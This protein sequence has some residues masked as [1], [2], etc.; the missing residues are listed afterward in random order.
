MLLT[1][2]AR[3][4]RNA[5][6]RFGP[7]VPVVLAWASV[8]QAPQFCDEQLLA[9]DEI[10]GR[11]LDA[12]PPEQRPAASAAERQRRQAPAGTCERSAPCCSGG[13][14][15]K[16]RGTPRAVAAAPARSAAADPLV[17]WPAM[18]MRQKYRMRTPSTGREVI[19]EAEPDQIYLDRET[20]EQLEVVGELLPLAP[21][22]RSCPGRWTTCASATGATS[23]RRR[24]STTA[25][26]AA[27]AWSRS[28]P[29]A[30]DVGEIERRNHRGVA[31]CRRGRGD[32]RALAARRCGGGGSG[33]TD[34]AG[35]A[36]VHGARPR[37]PS[38]AAGHHRLDARAPRPPRAPR[39]APA[40]A[41]APAHRPRSPR[42]RRA[43][44]RRPRPRRPAAPVPPRHRRRDGRQRRRHRRHGAGGSGR[45]AAAAPG[46][47]RPSASR[48]P[49]PASPGPLPAG[50]APAARPARPPAQSPSS[51]HV[52]LGVRRG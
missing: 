23:S 24:T 43:R 16:R 22:P 45:A 42:R 30:P 49:A 35:R 2:S 19:I 40:P 18:R 1:P 20:G 32:D 46:S 27:G 4:W 34:T 38:N 11:V 44:R 47:A 29:E 3:S 12:Q 13:T 50:Q 31:R 7:I 6:S 28:A 52:V 36:A 39:P 51:V 17:A 48:T 14:L 15:S 10:G 8:W 26:I 21:T 37:R 25:R 9:L 33:T 5:S 41:R